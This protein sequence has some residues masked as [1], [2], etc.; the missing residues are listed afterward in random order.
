MGI[1]AQKDDDK[2]DE[3]HKDLGKTVFLNNM[4]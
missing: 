1:S 2:F 4:Y 3:T